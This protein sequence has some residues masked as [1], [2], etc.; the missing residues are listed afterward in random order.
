MRIV[1][2]FG[3]SML[4]RAIL[5]ALVSTLAFGASAA[6]QDSGR[7]VGT[8]TESANG[9]PVAGAQVV[10][11]GTGIGAVSGQRGTYSL[12]NVPAGARTIVVTMLGFE[13]VREQVDV[14]GGSTVTLDVAL[15][16]GFVEMGAITVIGASR[17][18]TR[19]VEAPA[20][21]SVVTPEEVQREAAQKDD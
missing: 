15:P 19:I 7:I 17:R 1:S 3:A 8:V 18:P 6:A 11:E 10:V 2:E 12:P 4:E 14:A 9:A 21:V 13:T 16:A 20:A 5:V